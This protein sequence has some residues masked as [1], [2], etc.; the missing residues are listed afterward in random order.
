MKVV[1]PNWVFNCL[2]RRGTRRRNLDETGQLLGMQ[3]T[4]GWRLTRR[5]IRQLC[6]PL[7]R[8]VCDSKTNSR[9]LL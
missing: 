1:D 5:F 4:F 6:P 7:A 8:A 2:R 3:A 9:D